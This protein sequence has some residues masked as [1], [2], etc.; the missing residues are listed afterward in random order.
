MDDKLARMRE[1]W[2]RKARAEERRNEREQAQQDR[3][4][5]F[6]VWAARQE[7][8]LAQSDL[9]RRVSTS[10]A[11]VSRWES[12]RRYPSLPTLERVAQTTGLELVIGLRRPDA[13][14]DEFVALG[15][16][17]DEWPV[18]YPRMLH[19]YRGGSYSILPTAWRQ[20][21]DRDLGFSTANPSNRSC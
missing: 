10:R 15:A 11:A 19:D 14:D 7:A 9:A 6:L 1:R 2:E 17:Q 12:G 16:V 20:R 5:G 4:L 13:P 21:V 18:S 3:G 8:R